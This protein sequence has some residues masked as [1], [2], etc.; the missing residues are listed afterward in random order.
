MNK[1]Q[2]KGASR[3]VGSRPLTTDYWLLATGKRGF[4]LIEILVVIVILAVLAGIVVGAAKYAQTKAARSRAQ[5]EIATMESAL[6]H[7]K[8]DNGIYPPSTGNRSSPSPPGYPG[9]IE[10]SNSGSL[11]AALTTPK[12]YMTFKPNQ[13]A[14][15][16]VITYVVD[17]F[18]HPYNYYC[19]PGALDMSNA[20]TFDLWSYGP[21]GIND[22]GTNDDISNWK[23]N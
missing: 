15:N 23:Q 20:V 18:G 14:L 12:V 19:I 7:Y 17:P 8:N 21:N 22:E 9:V 11:Y 1:A 3:T 2:R 4:T 5:A 13:I 6:E 10:I 16:G